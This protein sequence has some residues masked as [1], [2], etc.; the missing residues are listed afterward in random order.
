MVQSCLPWL[1][2]LIASRLST[3]LNISNSIVKT[4]VLALLCPFTAIQCKMMCI[5]VTENKY[6]TVS[7]S[8]MLATGKLLS[9][10]ISKNAYRAYCKYS[11]L[12][13]AAFHFNEWR[14]VSGLT[15]VGNAN[16]SPEAAFML[17]NVVDHLSCRI[18]GFLN[19]LQCMFSV[20][21]TL[22]IMQMK[23]DLFLYV[24]EGLCERTEYVPQLWN[25]ENH[26]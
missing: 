17:K 20:E 9:T 3:R 19:A 14:Q 22:Y 1:N 15:A 8:I 6:L 10:F 13:M 2:C 7:L 5:F 12:S 25:W 11:R 21:C 4:S 24:I 18:V 26:S 23:C 16:L